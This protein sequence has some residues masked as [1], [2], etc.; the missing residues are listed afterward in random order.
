M[1]ARCPAARYA[2]VAEVCRPSWTRTRRSSEGIDVSEDQRRGDDRECDLPGGEEVGTLER[3]ERVQETCRTVRPRVRVPEG[4]RRG[5]LII[6][7]ERVSVLR[8]WSS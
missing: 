6:R 4:A 5:G 2:P 8:R 1:S 7:N 3:A